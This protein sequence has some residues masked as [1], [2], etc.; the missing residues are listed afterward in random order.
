MSRTVT[1][2][3]GDS[4]QSLTIVGSNKSSKMVRRKRGPCP[5]HESIRVQ[6]AWTGPEAHPTSYTMCTG[7][8]LRVRQ[9]G[10]G[11]DHPS[12]SSA[13]DANVLEL[14]LRLPPVP[15][16]ARHVFTCHFSSC[17]NS[18]KPSLRPE[19][20]KSSYETWQTLKRRLYPQCILYACQ[21]VHMRL[22]V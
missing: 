1:F 12:T 22:I 21:L 11:A 10:R 5:L 3:E 14:H 9:P 2:Y 17:K 20:N 6:G 15:A 16:Q 13:E 7:S 18:S 4:G 19:D 8:F